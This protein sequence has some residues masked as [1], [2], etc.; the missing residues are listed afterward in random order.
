MIFFGRNKLDPILKLKFKE[1][2]DGEVPVILFLRAPLSGKLKNSISKNMGKLKSEYKFF[3]CA[4]GL[5]STDAIDKL[6]ELPEIKS[7]SYD[8]KA[9]ICMESIQGVCGLDTLSPYKLTGKGIT[10]AI[11]DTGV[12]PHTDLMRPYRV[13]SC[14]KD[15]IKGNSLPYDDNGHGTQIC[16]IIAGSGITSEE[17]YAGLAPMSKIVML[18]AFNSVGEGSFSD[19]LSCIDWVIENREKLGIRILCLPFGAQSIVPS[20]IDPLCVAARA[21]WDAGIIVVAAAGNKGPSQGS[22]TT[23]GIEPSIITVGCCE[24]T[25]RDIKSWRIP[26]FSGRGWRRGTMVKPELTSPGV[27]M[28]SLFACRDYV[29]VPGGRSIPPP[30]D[31]PYVSATGSS[32]SAAFVSGCIALLLEKMPGISGKDLKGVL[33]LSCQSLNQ[34]STAQGYGVINLEKLLGEI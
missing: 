15:M 8:R 10:T 22:L 23:P 3:C 19:I 24:S 21:A 1:K 29:P 30:V 18:K 28:P 7:I 31:T 5:F 6:S 9:N 34:S 25:G 16:G 12:Y 14:F 33:K 11:I 32:V 17:R 4:S 27:N 26:D 2:K 13:V 20:S